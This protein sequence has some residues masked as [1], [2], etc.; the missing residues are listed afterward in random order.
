MYGVVQEVHR[1]GV[2]LLLTIC[3]IELELVRG[4][5]LLL[6]NETE[7]SICAN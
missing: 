4:A 1:T 3:S 7:T 2:V 5:V 6:S